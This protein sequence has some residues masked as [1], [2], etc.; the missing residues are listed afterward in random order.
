M[1]EISWTLEGEDVNYLNEGSLKDRDRCR[2]L[3]IQK[4]CPKINNYK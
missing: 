2:D 3:C 1:K 4:Q